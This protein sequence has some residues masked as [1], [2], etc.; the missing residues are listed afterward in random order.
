[1][2]EMV[3]ECLVR[4]FECLFGFCYGDCNGFGLVVVVVIWCFFD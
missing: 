2:G 4:E 1:M 3:C